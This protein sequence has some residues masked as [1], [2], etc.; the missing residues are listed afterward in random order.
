LGWVCHL[1]PKARNALAIV[2]PDTVVRWHRAG[3]PIVLAAKVPTPS[4]PSRGT[5]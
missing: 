1:F 2:R 5:G 3:L 4:R